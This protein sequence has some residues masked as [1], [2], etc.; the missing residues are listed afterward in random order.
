MFYTRVIVY[1]IVIP[2]EA[3]DLG[4]CSRQ[5]RIAAHA[6]TKVPRFAWDDNY[7]LF[8]YRL[9]KCQL[10]EES[11]FLPAPKLPHGFGQRCVSH[12]RRRQ[13]ENQH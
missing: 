7:Q 3:R 2:S 11:Y 9:F 6:R 13:R 1:R 10:L 5:T 4:V 12:W 8:D